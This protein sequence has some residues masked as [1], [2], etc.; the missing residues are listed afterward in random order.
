MTRRLNA[1]LPNGVMKVV[2]NLLSLD[3]LVCQNSK[4]RSILLNISQRKEDLSF[5][6]S[7]VTESSHA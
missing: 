7:Q 4:F 6:L 5:G 3:N 1:N 2:S